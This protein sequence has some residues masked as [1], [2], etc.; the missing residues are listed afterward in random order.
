MPPAYPQRLTTQIYPSHSNLNFWMSFFADDVA[1]LTFNCRCP[2]GGKADGNG[3]NLV[4]VTQICLFDMACPGCATSRKWL[5]GSSS[6]S[7]HCQLS[8]SMLKSN[9]H[10]VAQPGQIMW[11]MKNG[12]THARLTPIALSRLSCLSGRHCSLG[13]QSTIVSIHS[14]YHANSR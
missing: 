8:R 10:Q 6:S 1:D 14:R 3:G 9:F 11:N 12:I 5:P 2:G 4:R 7:G 13:L